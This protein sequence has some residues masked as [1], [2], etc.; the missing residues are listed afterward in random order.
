MVPAQE[1]LDSDFDDPPETTHP[2]VEG[3][4]YGAELEI[5]LS[6]EDGLDLGL[7]GRERLL[8]AEPM[9][10]LAFTF[11]PNETFR[12]FL[13]FELSKV[14]FDHSEDGTGSGNTRLE[15][16]E[17]YFVLREL[18]E[19][20]TFQLGRQN[21]EDEL[22]WYYDRELDAARAYYR[23]EGLVLEGSVSQEGL[24]Q[25]DLLNDD[26]IEAVTNA[27]L[28]GHA[29]LGEESLVSAFFLLREARD[30]E[31]E[32]LGFLGLQSTGEL[33]PD[34]DYWVNLAAVL[35]RGPDSEGAPDI[36]GIGF[37]FLASY[38]TELPW[39]PSISFGYG[40]GSGDGDP[41]DGHDGNFRQTGLQDN[42]SELNGVTDLKYYGELFD[43][44]LSNLSLVT[45]GFGLRPS[46]VSSIDLIYH[47]Y[48]QNSAS[49]TL[50][51]PSLGADPDGRHKG[52]GHEL[53]LILG[54]HVAQG[55]SLEL[56]LG[57]F[58][59]GKAFG[60]DSEPAF[61]AALEAL[62]AF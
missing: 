3:L 27:F 41:S 22:Q 49:E 59:P 51:N 36:R 47:Y 42:E 60:P 52:L 26:E 50:R 12:L 58:L 16:K 1:A 6:Y 9:G 37:D 38:V 45:L 44:E 39:E 24:V 48:R 14:F 57:A 25:V 7:D 32:D 17:A 53:D 34:L 55:M 19:G 40:Y 46:E 23:L 13:D 31:G 20:L 2:I 30:K 15:V 8:T 61:L 10:E 4:S 28:I 29:R 33:R 18:A 43:P 35:G 62:I 54:H 56:T 5:D 21:F 11:E